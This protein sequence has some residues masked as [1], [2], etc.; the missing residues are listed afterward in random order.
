MTQQAH[1]S[2]SRYCSPTACATPARA[3]ARGGEDPDGGLR[4]HSSLGQGGGSP[5]HLRGRQA[6][7]AA[8][9]PLS[10]LSPLTID[11]V[12][13]MY[14]H[15]AEIQAI[16]AVQ[17]AEC[18]RWLQ[19]DSTPCPIQ[20]RTGR[21]KPIMMPSM[22]RLVPSPPT[23]THARQGSEG[24]LPE[25]RVQ[26]PRWGGRSKFFRNTFKEPCDIASYEAI[27]LRPA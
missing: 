23:E 4:L 6:E 20:A 13:K 1:W 26:S 11:W 21:P 19:S 16:A 7:A 22:I 5:C 25:R 3:C 9:K 2:A 18:A 24:A 8:T 27:L 15:L 10:A 12:E 17:L 14:C